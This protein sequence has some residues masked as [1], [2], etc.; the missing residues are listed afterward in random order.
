MK[1][2]QPEI[3]HF[4][5]DKATGYPNSPLPVRIPAN[6]TGHSGDRDRFAHSLHAGE[7]FVR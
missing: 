1:D 7:S 4:D 6:V 5:S 2:P 3:L